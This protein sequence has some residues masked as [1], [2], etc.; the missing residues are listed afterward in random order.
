MKKIVKNKKIL[1]CVITTLILISLI[2]GGIFLFSKDDEEKTQNK[3]TTNNYVAYVKINPVIKLEFSQTCRNT[4]EAKNINSE[5]D[6]PVVTKYELINKDAQTIYKDVDLIDVTDQLWSVLALISETAKEHNIIVENVDIYSDWTKLDQYIDN[7]TNTEY[8]WT[9]NVN[10]KEKEELQDIENSLKEEK[11]IYTVTFD[12]DGGNFIQKQEVE[13]GTKIN[14][15]TS[16]TKKGYKFIEWQLNN[17][18][19]DFSS[20][21]EENI[22][23]VA[24]WEKINTTNNNQHNTNNNQNNTTDNKQENSNNQNNNSNNN[25]EN[26]NDNNTPPVEEIVY[27]D[28]PWDIINNGTYEQFAKEHGITINLVAD[29]KY[30]CSSH[31]SAPSDPKGY[32][33]GDVVTAYGYMEDVCVENCDGCSNEECITNPP[34]YEKMF[35]FGACGNA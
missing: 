23:L 7:Q 16:P 22:T 21:I 24:K 18:K 4:D 15:P 20:T 11:I 28:I 33:K 6:N 1:I 35:Q 32:K 3:E 27:F 10:I 2:V 13:K 31:F 14:Q 34:R 19:F 9:Y 30:G 26:K 5:C 8:T 29:D 12:T 17:E 25:T